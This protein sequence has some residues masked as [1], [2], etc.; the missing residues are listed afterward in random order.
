MCGHTSRTISPSVRT[1]S[2]NTPCVDGCC[3]PILMSSSSVLSE[4]CMRVGLEADVMICVPEKLPVTHAVIFIRLLVVFAKRVAR[5][6]IRQQDSRQ[7]VMTLEHDSQHVVGLALVPV[8][9]TPEVFN[10]SK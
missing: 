8:G 1:R 5:P 7:V 9:S 4:S 6:V 3:G 10:R 2:L